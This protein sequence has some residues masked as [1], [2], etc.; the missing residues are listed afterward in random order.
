MI[1][2]LFHFPIDLKMIFVP[3]KGIISTNPSHTCWDT[4]INAG[5]CFKFILPHDLVMQ[6]YP[7]K[8]REPFQQKEKNI[9]QSTDLSPCIRSFSVFATIKFRKMLLITTNQQRP[10]FYILYTLN[11]NP[12]NLLISIVFMASTKIIYEHTIN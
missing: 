10:R 7:P 9:R 8:T 2:F 11:G 6:L 1:R 3:F 5:T 4:P 12:N